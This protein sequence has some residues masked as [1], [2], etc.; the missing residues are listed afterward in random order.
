[1]KGTRIFWFLLPVAAALLSG[2]V[3]KKLWQ[4]D[5]FRE[6]WPEPHLQLT[7]D[8][9]RKDVLVGYDELNDRSDQRRPRAY[10]LFQNEKRIMAKRKPAFVDPAKMVKFPPVS[11]FSGL[12]PVAMTTNLELVAVTATNNASFKLYSKGKPLGEF[13]LPVYKDGVW[14][15]QKALLMPLAVGADAT[16]VGGVLGVVW[17]ELGGPGVVNTPCK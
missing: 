9:D 14:Q 1:M 4:Q 15:A 8:Q 3:T 7:F 10:Y 11:V 17:L 16:V 2:C 5:A 13:F 6:P 12:Q